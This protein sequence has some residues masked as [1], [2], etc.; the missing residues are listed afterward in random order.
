M[1]ELDC[2]PCFEVCTCVV[3]AR[4]APQDT[5]RMNRLESWGK[6]LHAKESFNPMTLICI[7]ARAVWSLPSPQHTYKFP[8]KVR[9]HMSKLRR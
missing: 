2:L 9:Q 8:P 1:M 3:W 6:A 5:C 4:Q 7:L